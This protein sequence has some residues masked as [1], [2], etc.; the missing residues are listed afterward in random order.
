MKKFEEYL[1]SQV[2]DAGDAGGDEE[3]YDEEEGGEEYWSRICKSAKFRSKSLIDR[4]K[5]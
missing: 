3:Y 1:K 2:K 5:P 4:F